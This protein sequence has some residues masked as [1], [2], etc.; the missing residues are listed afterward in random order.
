MVEIKHA[1]LLLP[2]ALPAA[3]PESR[4]ERLVE[5]EHKL[6]IAQT[7]DALSEMRIYLRVRQTIFLYKKVHVTGTGQGPNTRVEQ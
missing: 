1:S 5:G 3:K 2:S 6:G 4:P 7:E